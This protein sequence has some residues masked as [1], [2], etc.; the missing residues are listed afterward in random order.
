MLK[1]I[2]KLKFRKHYLK[3]IF[4]IVFISIIFLKKDFFLLT[5]FYHDTAI[6][7]PN[8]SVKGWNK[9]KEGDS[10]N[11]VISIIG[12]PL[13]KN[14]NANREGKLRFIYSKPKDEHIFQT[15]IEVYIVFDKENRVQKLAK[16][17][18]RRDR[19]RLDFW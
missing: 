9:I 5:V 17:L 6:Y 2:N 16:Y 4:L 3:L 8:Y 15:Y 19:A 7:A 11:R 1:T 13:Y 18:V 10:M 12:E 14:K